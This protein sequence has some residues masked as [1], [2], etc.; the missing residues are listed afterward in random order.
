MFD[1]VVN[2]S[3]SPLFLLILK[4]FLFNFSWNIDFLDSSTAYEFLMTSYYDVTKFEKI[5]LDI[6][7]FLTHFQP[8]LHLWINQVKGF[9]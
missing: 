6:K 9:Y 8:I 7:S 3:L 4:S 1:K 5:L 2:T